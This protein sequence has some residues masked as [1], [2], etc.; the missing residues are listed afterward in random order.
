MNRQSS[1]SLMGVFNDTNEF[2]SSRTVQ[3]VSLLSSVVLYS[4]HTSAIQSSAHAQD[5]ASEGD[6]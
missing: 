2:G 3:P 6:K 1:D 5:E 4:R